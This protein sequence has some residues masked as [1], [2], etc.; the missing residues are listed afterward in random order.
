MQRVAVLKRKHLIE[1]KEE[2]LKVQL[3]ATSA[4]LNVLEINSSVCGSKRSDGRNSYF[5]KN[6]CQ[7]ANVLNPDANMF[8]PVTLDKKVNVTDVP[9]IPQP[10][11]VMP[12]KS[13][14]TRRDSYTKAEVLN[15]MR[16]LARE[17]MTMLVV[18][19][20]MAFARDVSNHVVFMSQGVICEEGVP[21]EVFGNPQ[22]QETKDFLAR[23]RSA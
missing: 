21:S 8:V 3:A 7:R 13:R 18:T 16:S 1:D 22:R 17:G 6:I 19:H 9:V 14:E 10:Q 23:F 12:K 2:K 11:A 5:E 4:K 20:E 15:V